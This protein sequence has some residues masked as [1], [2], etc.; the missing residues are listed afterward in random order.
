MIG[1]HWFLMYT[2]M[3]MEESHFRISSFTLLHKVSYFLIYFPPSSLLC[4]HMSIEFFFVL[5]HYTKLTN[6]FLSSLATKGGK[7]ELQV[8][9]AGSKRNVIKEAQV[10][11]VCSQ[12]YD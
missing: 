1:I 11:K 6:F 12:I 4:P 9:Y 7:P 3:T 5:E 2:N 10:T 8:M